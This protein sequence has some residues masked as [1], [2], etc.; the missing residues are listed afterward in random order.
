MVRIRAWN[1]AVIPAEKC[2]I[3]SHA[4]TGQY[5]QRCDWLLECSDISE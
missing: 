5:F 3:G 2:W 1:R 4:I